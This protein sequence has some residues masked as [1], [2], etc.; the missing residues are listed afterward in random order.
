MA[1]TPEGRVKAAIKTLL[2]DRGV[3]FYMPVSNG[4]GTMGI[5]DFVCC[6]NGWFLGI[7]AKA[8][9]KTHTTTAL[10]E[11]QIALIH[12]A[13]G[14]AIVADNVDTVATVLNRLQALSPRGETE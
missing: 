10:Q 11:R 2:K 7:E 12:K 5:P 4:M 6:V 13:G 14:V 8:P 1:A 3:W 9:G